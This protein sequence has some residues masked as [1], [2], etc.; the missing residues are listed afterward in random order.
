MKMNHRRTRALIAA[1]WCVVACAAAAKETHFE[2]VKF[3]LV[4]EQIRCTHCHVGR[5][6]LELTVYGRKIAELGKDKTVQDR[7]REMEAEVAVTASDQER[8]EAKSRTDVDADGVANWI[9]MLSGRDPSAADETSPPVD[10]FPTVERVSTFVQC[11]ICHIRVDAVA[12]P[13]KSRAPHNA[14]GKTLTEFD[15]RGKR[16]RGKAI[17]KA[18]AE[19]VDF[20]QRLD[21][22]AKEDA[23]LDS[24]TNWDEISTLHSPFDKSDRPNS[25]ETKAMRQDQADRRKSDEGFGQFHKLPHTP[26]RR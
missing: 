8:D 15:A 11:T 18:D 4:S 22:I 14:F 16:L 1:V 25:D 17:E 26:R 3:R 12:G 5:D 23:D 2:E 10:G 13:G 19:D 21:V 20:A 7:V 24:A 9:E 6:D